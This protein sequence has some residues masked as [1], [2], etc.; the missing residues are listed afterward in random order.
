MKAV[1]LA[2]LALLA[3][4][5]VSAA[6]QVRFEESFR[7]GARIEAHWDLTGEWALGPDGL[8]TRG[9]GRNTACAFAAPELGR[10]TI[11][12]RMTI[13]PRAGAGSWAY[14]GLLLAQD[15]GNYWHLALVE[16]P[17]GDRYGE[18]VQELRGAWQAQAG[19]PSRLE[20]TGEGVKERW[21]PGDFDFTLRL[22]AAGIEGEIAET[23]SGRAVF[24]GGYRFAPEVAAVR[25]GRVG[26]EAV[27]M[28]ASAREV[29]VSSEQS[30]AH[31]QDAR[32][33]PRAAVLSAALPGMPP[34]LPAAIAAALREGGVEADLLAPAQIA[35]AERFSRGRYSVVVAP[36]CQTFPG[37]AR[38]G[39]L[40][41]LREGGNL[42]A[43]GGPIFEQVVW[44]CDGQWLSED[45]ILGVI[46]P[47]RLI[48]DWSEQDLAAWKRGSSHP[49]EQT[50]HRVVAGQ[51]GPTLRMDVPRLE[52]WDTF[53][54]PRL[55][56]AFA[57]GRTLTVFS[58]KANV[59]T[60]AVVEWVERDGSRW[61]AP[62]NLT[63]EW[64]RFA[65]PP[66]A[67][68]YWHDNPSKGRGGQGD[69][70]HV[71]EVDHL[72]LGLAIGFGAQAGGPYTVWFS[73]IGTAASPLGDTGFEPPLLEGMSPE[74]KI[75]RTSA[76]R[77]QSDYTK[78]FLRG[79]RL[80][81]PFEAACPIRRS[82]G[83]GSAGARP[84]RWA[85]LLYAYDRAS[86][87]RGAAASTYVSLAGPFRNATW[88]QIGIP[89]SAYLRRHLD[90]LGPMLADV[91]GRV[92]AG[93]W[94]TKAGA[95]RFSYF[96]DEPVSV[97][98][99]VSNFTDRPLTL[100]CGF[101]I[102]R[103]SEEIVSGSAEAQVGARSTARVAAPWQAAPLKPGRY[104]VIV[105]LR[106]DGEQVDR[107]EH[108]FL[109]TEPPSGS[110]AE[111]VSV[112]EGEFRLDGEQWNPHGINYW[113]S[114]A[115]ALEPFAYWLHW[116]SPGQYDPEVVGRDLSA[117]E[118]LGANMVS[119]QYHSPDQAPALNDFLRQA[120]GNGIR[121]NIFLPGAHPLDIN[122]AR[123]T[124]LIKA[125]RLAGNPAVFAYDIAWEPA[126]GD[127]GSRRRY[128]AQWTAW[129]KDR[130]GSVE[131]AARDWGFAPA[132]REDG[133]LA[134]PTQEQILNDGEH[135]RM[136]A[137]YRRFVD[138]MISAGYN[139][140]TRALRA[141]DPTHLI[142]ARTGYGGTG[143]AGIDPRMPFDLRA[144]AKHLDFVSPE[145]WGLRGEWENFE[146][147]GFTTAY[148]RWASNGK[149]VFWSE[150]GLT[151]Y[152]HTTPEKVEAQGEQYRNMYRMVLASGADG[153]AGWWFPGGLR[154][155]ENSDYGIMNPDA[156]LRPG[157]RALREYAAAIRAPRERK[158]PDVWITINRDLHP[159]GY[160][161]VWARHRQAYLEARRA[162][163]TVGLRTEGTGTTSADCPPVAVGDVPWN[164][165]NP[166]KY[167]NAGFNRVTLQG[168]TVTASVGNTGEAKWLSR[169]SAAGR[170]GAVYLLALADGEEVA[171]APIVG[172]VPR[173]GDAEIRLTL[174]EGAGGTRLVMMAEGRTRFGPTWALEAAG[175]P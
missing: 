124:E 64:Q 45:E 61:I 117:L 132:R 91:A 133:S 110:P 106:Q 66:E 118:M 155:D 173:F 175:G 80:E 137:A 76:F 28:A 34:D 108:E 81:E 89:D 114:Y 153:S 170:P 141:L 174:P 165:G 49:E 136:V 13:G 86:H 41:F 56:G 90:A 130:Y 10:Q 168:R 69:C 105:M 134:G 32:S 107:I 149:P 172:D 98:A 6:G 47:D 23:G 125:A 121:V 30:E 109:V 11:T 144:G 42:I 96:E 48:V 171:R 19:G 35:D 97:A 151:V 24:R 146:A 147:A 93:F 128:D 102:R 72:S 156:T 54:S 51:G 27:E 111:T 160:S 127:E 138:D 36:Q 143:Q 12:A 55:E 74:H 115:T 150:F 77:A 46:E 131:N 70:L 7:P 68:R 148:G 3:A 92:S 99:Y 75:Y 88:T 116:L 9:V 1:T 78:P 40:R 79:A 154:I 25:S 29:R 62:V 159:R 139:R 16:S 129:V 119:I 65:L 94:L 44:E 31:G 85:P 67:F 63:P 59:A 38:E 169:E 122:E 50:T 21:E 87:L 163:G 17:T 57:E 71:E 14:A 123:F 95:D 158:A 162:G 142:G 167:L 5:A 157:A 60:T 43:T 18:L 113:P 84:G 164:G 37:P 145:G 112:S 22:S 126:L 52:G 104:L 140:V 166:P 15:S 135:R 20:P 39:V 103:W 120:W 161:Q 26:L 152:P 8:G 2:A 53:E 58:A 100:R 73:G 83:L 82:R 33:A 101:V 4:P